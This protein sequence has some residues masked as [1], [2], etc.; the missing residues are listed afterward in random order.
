MFEYR[1]LT[2]LAEFEQV[3]DLEIHIWGVNE[4][5]A[6]APHTIKVILHAGGCLIGCYSGEQLVGF[7]IGLAMP[8]G[9]LWSH[10][11]GVHP[12]YQQR[13]IGYRLKQTQR[14]WAREAGFTHMHWTFDPLQ[15][16]NAHFNL[17]QLNVYV[18][19]YHVNFY[20]QMLDE[21][22][23]GL[24]S[25][26]L[27]VTWVLDGSD[28]FAGVLTSAPND[29]NENDENEEEA[30]PLLLTMG[31]DYRPVK[32]QGVQHDAWHRLQIPADLDELRQVDPKLILQWRL[33]VREAFQEALANG[34]VAVD[35][36]KGDGK[37]W[38]LFYRQ[39]AEK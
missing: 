15:R 21:I 30:A 3:A 18:E 31:D 19:T 22:N 24:P 25:D 26:R 8:D 20:G 10:I 7:V 17:R 2:Q 13:G 37:N 12:D 39:D 5:Y 27:Q 33:A 35:F 29:E 14:Q 9:R 36:V 4:R 6:I 38:Y 11:A 28:P 16:V 32:G 34:Y 1:L 23:S